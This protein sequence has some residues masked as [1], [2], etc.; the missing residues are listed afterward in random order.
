MAPK[1]TP[2]KARKTL[3]VILL[4]V[5]VRNNGGTAAA[6]WELDEAEAA[7]ED[8]SPVG[9]KFEVLPRGCGKPLE[10]LGV[11]GPLFGELVLVTVILPLGMEF[12]KP[13]VVPDIAAAS[14]VGN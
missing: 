12:G 13:E 6:A 8:E 1:E 2:A 9:G 11:P 10:P 4:S 7:P 5:L 3:V 14:A